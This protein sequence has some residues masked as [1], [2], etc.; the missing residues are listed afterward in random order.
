ML[1]IKKIKNH[2]IMTTKITTATITYDIISPPLYCHLDY[3][4]L[5]CGTENKTSEYFTAKKENCPIMFRKMNGEALHYHIPGKENSS[6]KCFTIAKYTVTLPSTENF[7]S[8]FLL[9]SVSNKK[10]SQTLLLKLWSIPSAI[11]CVLTKFSQNPLCNDIQS[12]AY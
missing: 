8:I 1:G 3:T 10:C 5:N 4:T 6:F 11:V 12:T 9:V 7:C 2:C